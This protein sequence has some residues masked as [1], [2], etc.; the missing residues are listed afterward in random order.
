MS[1]PIKGMIQDRYRH[2][3]KMP[4][5]E[6]LKLPYFLQQKMKR[7][8]PLLDARRNLVKAVCGQPRAQEP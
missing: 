8:R 6:E 7:D 1:T 4:S 5:D 3:F 2:I